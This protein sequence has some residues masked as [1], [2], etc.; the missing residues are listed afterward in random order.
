MSM[1]EAAARGAERGAA[2]RGQMSHHAGDAAEQAVARN[3]E[4]RGYEVVQRRWR[5]AGGEIDLIARGPEGLVFI[6]VK[7]SRSFAEAAEHLGARQIARICAS[8]E[9]FLASEPAGALTD[10]RFDVALV[11]AS[12]GVRIIENAFG[13]G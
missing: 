7:Q 3:Y 9:S 10:L 2:C 13:Q 1:G 4:R 11:D 5:G 12:G 6:E 8:A